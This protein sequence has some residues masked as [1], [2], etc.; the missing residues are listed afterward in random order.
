MAP[1]N[2]T[3]KPNMSLRLPSA[4]VLGALAC[5]AAGA[6]IGYYFG[7]P[8]VILLAIVIVHLVEIKQI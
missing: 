1:E 2:N 6:A 3:S 8:W 7:W 5:A 4:R